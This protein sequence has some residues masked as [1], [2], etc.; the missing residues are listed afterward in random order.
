MGLM[1]Y[2]SAAFTDNHR[3]QTRMNTGV[4]AAARHRSNGEKRGLGREI[5]RET[6]VS[7]ASGTQQHGPNPRQ[8]WHLWQIR[9][10]PAQGWLLRIGGVQF[11]TVRLALGGNEYCCKLV[12]SWGMP[13]YR[14][15][16][17][18]HRLCCV[19]YHFNDFQ[20]AIRRRLIFKVTRWS[21]GKN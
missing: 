10:K 21:D 8:H 7:A 6:P 4:R 9:K 12:R 17:R 11:S 16:D 20:P 13:L 19:F 2:W 3:P 15:L 14:L 5:H 18:S 1:G